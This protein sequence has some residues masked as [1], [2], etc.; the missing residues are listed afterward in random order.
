MTRGTVAR[1]VACGGLKSKPDA[2]AKMKFR[3]ERAA[4][5][6]NRLLEV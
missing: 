2:A 1:F 6:S 5:L 4:P 3:G